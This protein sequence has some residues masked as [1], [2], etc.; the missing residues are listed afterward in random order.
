MHEVRFDDGLGKLTAAERDALLERAEHCVFQRGES[1]L[2]E[3][4]HNDSLYVIAE[5]HVRVERSVRVV[6]HFRA[7]NGGLARR[8]EDDEGS[9]TVEIARL[10]RGA[11]FGEMS[12]LEDLP[13]S[14]TVTAL[15]GVGAFRISQR[16][17]DEF[18]GQD[19]TFAARFFQSLAV[20]LAH[21]LRTTNRRL[22]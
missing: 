19:S 5:G 17:I 21:R 6:A 12:F 3:G 10:G 20:T 2:E 15:D 1:I 16:V 8:A 18:C 11:I 22:A 4:T 9:R 14:A 13:A 7:I